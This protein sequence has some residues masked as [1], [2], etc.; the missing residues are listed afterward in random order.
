MVRITT[1][2]KEY[3]L[4]IKR[5]VYLQKGVRSLCIDY[6]DNNGDHKEFNIKNEKDIDITELEEFVKKQE[7]IKKG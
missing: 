1:T 6:F 7:R 4:F 2:K 3:W 5:I